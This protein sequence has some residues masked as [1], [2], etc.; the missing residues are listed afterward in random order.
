MQIFYFSPTKIFLWHYLMSD[1]AKSDNLLA[2]KEYDPW[3]NAALDST[4]MILDTTGWSLEW[5]DEKC[6]RIRGICLLYL[7]LPTITA[8]Y[9]KR[10]D[11]EI[12]LSG[13]L[14]DRFLQSQWLWLLPSLN[15][16]WKIQWNSDI[17]TIIRILRIGHYWFLSVKPGSNPDVLGS[18]YLKTSAMELKSIH[19]IISLDFLP[20]VEEENDFFLF[21]W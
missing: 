15:A 14:F 6:K 13:L 18:C 17:V 20:H 4:V 9:L 21:S 19:L 16:S 5:K 1:N 12:H 2:E 10:G 3:V 8:C 11:N 7:F